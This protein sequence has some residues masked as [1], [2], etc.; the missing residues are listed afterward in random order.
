[1]HAPDLT[2]L[3]KFYIRGRWV[4]PISADQMLVLNPT[5]E[6]QVG[7][8]SLGNRDDVIR[9]VTAANE[10]FQS[11]AQPSKDDRLS[12]LIAVKAITEKRLEDLAQ[13]MHIEMGAPISMAPEWPMGR[14]LAATNSPATVA[15]VGG[16]GWRIIWRQKPCMGSDPAW[17]QT[18]NKSEYQCK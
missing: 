16:W 15:K 13:A 7:T 9:A 5:T 10:A 3:G 8:V 18:S 1:M 11:Y 6:E 2:N 12:L 14:L 4:D 17:E